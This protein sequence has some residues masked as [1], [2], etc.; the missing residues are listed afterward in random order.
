MIAL[1]KNLLSLRG[2]EYLTVD[3]ALNIVELSSSVQRYADSRFEVGQACWIG[4]PELV[5]IEADLI[6]VLKE[7][8][9]KVCYPAIARAQPD[10]RLI[11]FDL[12]ALK[13]DASTFMRG[14]LILFLEDV[15][16]RLNLEQRLVQGSN[17]LSLLN[18]RNNHLL[19]NLLPNSI[20]NQLKQEQ[21]GTCW[22]GIAEH[23][24]AATILFADLVG[25]T[26]LTTQ[27]SAIRLVQL[28]NQIFSAFDRLSDRYELEKIKTI[29]DAYMVVAGVPQQRHDH[30]EAIAEMA[31]SM[32]IELQ[33]FNQEHNQTLSM[34]IGIHSGS[35]VAG[36]IGIKKFS[37]DLWGDA[38]NIASRM[39]SH[40]LAGQIQVSAAT[41]AQLEHKYQFTARGKIPIKGKGEMSTYF[42]QA[43][44]SERSLLGS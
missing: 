21:P 12:Y 17:E 13:L 8:Q 36:V 5:G 22:S 9:L 10:G 24:E 6:A 14:S 16:D 25:F 23:Y 11:Y 19:Q 3:A 44:V 32:Q 29:G 30:A 15:S 1:F 28:L 18:Q 35:V 20:V 2:I 26:Q 7:S 38:V 31:L 41:Y 33:R 37:Y 40:G 39:E 27:L 4:L 34:R 42:L 43:R